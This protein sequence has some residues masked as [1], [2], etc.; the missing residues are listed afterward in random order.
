M[1]EK[2]SLK[3]IGWL[4]VATLGAVF[5]LGLALLGLSL[6]SASTQAAP[7]AQ[8]GSLSL[9]L[10]VEKTASRA[11]V[12][13]IT[14]LS[15]EIATTTHEFW[16]VGSEAS[17]HDFVD[18]LD[19]LQ[20][21]SYDLADIPEI[22]NDVVDEVQISS[23]QPITGWSNICPAT[24][25]SA[26]SGDWRDPAT[27]DLGRV[28]NQDD[29]V[30]INPG[31]TVV[32]GPPPSGGVL[33]GPR[34]SKV[35]GL[36]NFGTLQSD[37]N[38]TLQIDATGFISNY[39]TIQG[40]DGGIV[41]GGRCG[42]KGASIILRVWGGPIFNKGFIEAGR[43]G[44]GERCGGDGGSTMVLGR[45]TTNLGT[46]CAG[47]GG[48]VL[49][50]GPGRGGKGGDTH[51]WGKYG[52]PGFLIN[53]GLACAGNGGWGNFGADGSQ[54][55][56]D[57]GTL[58]LI[59]LPDVFLDGGVHRAGRGG[60][61]TGG[62]NDGR[63]GRV[64]IEPNT[65]S[66]SGTGTSV[67]GGDIIIFGGDDWVLDLSGM[68]SAAIDASGNIT[69]AVGIGGVVDLSGNTS[70]VLQAG[71][72]VV[73]A[74]DVISLGAGVLL[75]D[76]VG[77][78]FVTSSSRILYDVS[79]VGPGQ[80]SGLPGLAVPIT[81]TIL[82]GGPMTDTYALGAQDSPGWTVRNLPPTK[83]VGGLDLADFSFDVR[84]A[85][86]AISGEVRV[87]TITAMSLADP[88]AAAIETVEVSVAFLR[89]IYLPL[90][91]KN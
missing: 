61:G 53:K 88:N 20:T 72:Q 48:N 81:M 25:R 39:A 80:A 21:K 83:T 74:S 44:N 27:W 5:V 24:I 11:T 15:T 37:G 10:P 32:G 57:G 71:G 35:Y 78:N 84:P 70:Q 49:G 50:T 13:T 34:P 65:I 82:N 18:Q 90:V 52:G 59:S 47:D 8:A 31:H 38:R 33:L 43:G 69:L 12:Y 23:N 36:C 86:T 9:T 1:T 77:T 76:V 29:V 75:S 45:N 51:I 63:D 68:S 42:G 22:P 89:N 56:G 6:S 26:A 67:T 3:G 4:L 85:A 62:G 64:I 7:V 55:G 54:S 16:D 87:I 58:K 17:L 60:Q 14:N 46:I 73:I 41:A 79:L 2:S 40:I 19:P 30:M 28:P 91:L 66:L